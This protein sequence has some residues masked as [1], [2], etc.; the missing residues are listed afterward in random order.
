MEG[1]ALVPLRASLSS[2]QENTYNGA[3]AIAAAISSSWPRASVIPPAPWTLAVDS[4]Q[5]HDACSRAR[6]RRGAQPRRG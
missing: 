2:M 4:T 5:N 6:G 1:V 3:R